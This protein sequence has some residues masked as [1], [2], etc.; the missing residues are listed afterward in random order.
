MHTTSYVRSRVVSLVASVFLTLVFVACG[1]KSGGSST[2]S[3]PTAPSSPTNHA[4]GI[5]AMSFSP[6][7]G[8]M[9]LTKFSFS[10]SASDPDG[11]A[12]SY[13]WDI[14]G[15]PASG[16][17]GSLIF[18][19]GGNGLARLTVTDTKGATA[20]DTRSFVVGDM[21][22]TWIVSSGVLTG[23]VF[24]L[25][26]SPAGTVTGNFT[27]PGFGDGKTD[28]AEPGHITASG[29]LTMRVK[30]TPF[31][32]F[33]MTGTMASSGGTVNGNLHGSGFTGESFSLT[34]Q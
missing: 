14:S 22:G 5:T 30:I 18:S 21:T 1:G 16:T 34:K 4:P 20:T 25:K 23:T 7:F 3:S 13:A 33:T 8:I 29:N 19:R 31:T 27:I 15:T 26:Q 12:V 10:A 17:S 24:V 9:G 32:D 6:V 28:P 2:T 11:D